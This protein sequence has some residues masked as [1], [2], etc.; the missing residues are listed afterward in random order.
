MS[1]KWISATVKLVCH[2]SFAIPVAEYEKYWPTMDAECSQHG[3]TTVL[4][5]SRLGKS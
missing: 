5:V 4:R 1:E 3:G 2:C